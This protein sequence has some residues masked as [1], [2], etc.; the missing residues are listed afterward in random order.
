MERIGK[1]T[2]ERAMYLFT[3]TVIIITAYIVMKYSQIVPRVKK[4][5]QERPEVAQT[6]LL[7]AVVLVV[8][9]VL[10]LV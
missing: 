4:Q 10:S 8:T 6:V 2:E 5:F 1:Y 3:T 9:I 7:A